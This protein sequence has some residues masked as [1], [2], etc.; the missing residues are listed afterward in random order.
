MGGYPLKHPTTARGMLALLWFLDPIWYAGLFRWLRA[1]R[2]PHQE[3]AFEPRLIGRFQS[4][5]RATVDYLETVRWCTPKALGRL[6]SILG[7]VTVRFEPG[8]ATVETP[9]PPESRLYKVFA[10]GENSAT[11]ECVV[12]RVSGEPPKPWRWTVDFTDDGY[13]TCTQFWWLWWYRE[14]FTRLNGSAPPTAT[15]TPS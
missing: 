2:S 4:D 8:V 15:P 7:T 11:V 13:W 12:E 3:I 5:R 14:K 10:R 9:G 6:A 1:R